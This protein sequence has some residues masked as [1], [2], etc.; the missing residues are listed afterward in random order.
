M[1]VDTVVSHG[2]WFNGWGSWGY[3]SV[4]RILA[5]IKRAGVRK[6][7]WRTFFGARAMYHSALEQSLMGDEGIDRPGNEAVVRMRYDLRSWDPLKD[8]VSVSRELQLPIHAWYTPYEE[9]HYQTVPTTFTLE[10]PEYRQMTRDWKRRDSKLSFASP[11]VCAH[12]LA[13]IEEQLAYGVAGL[14]LDF[15]REHH[16]VT[17]SKGPRVDVDENGV[18]IYGYEPTMVEAF[19]KKHGVD[20]MT[21][22]NDDENWLRFRCDQTTQFMRQV[23]EATAAR[24]VPVCVKVRSMTQARSGYWWPPERAKTNSYRGSFVDWPTWSKEGLVDELMVILENWDLMALDWR[25]VWRETEAARALLGEGKNLTIGFFMNNMHDCPVRDGERQ[26]HRCATAAIQAG[27]D[28]VCLW[29]ST[30]IHA[31]GSVR[32]GG[33]GTGIGLWPAV[34]RLTSTA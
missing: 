11:A 1:Q 34:T 29:E 4:Y 27:A 30:G 33:S 5:E 9:S 26:L 32:G 8:A 15:F 17:A 3:P 20:P 7:H 28:A 19:Q 12:K 24:G 18:C 13:L 14:T 6:V 10:H 25:E 22:A 21:L 31:W 23:R 16:V 2:D